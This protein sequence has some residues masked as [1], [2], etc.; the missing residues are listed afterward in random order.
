[1]EI[2][3]VDQIGDFTVEQKEIPRSHGRPYFLNATTLIGV[4]HT[5]EGSGIDSAWSTLNKNVDPPHF[6][7]GQN[8]IIQ[9]RPLNV[10]A[11]SLR[12][13]NGNTANVH[14]QIQIEMV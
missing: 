5:T 6:I 7:T 12:P 9:C 10:Q 2:K 4:L 13:G 1:M 11:A 8:R 14:A 3:W